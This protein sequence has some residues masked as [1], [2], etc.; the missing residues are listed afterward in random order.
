MRHVAL[1]LLGTGLVISAQ[2]AVAQV[3]VWNDRPAF[4]ASAGPVTLETF[5]DR[6]IF[7]LPSSINANTNACGTLTP[8]DCVTP[9]YLQPGITY[10]LP[11]GG[12]LLIDAGGGF[13]GA[14]LDAATP[15]YG[16]IPP[17]RLALWGSASFIGFDTNILAGTPLNV[18]VF[19]TG[20]SWSQEFAIAN[21]LDMQFL[22]FSRA[23]GDITAIELESRNPAFFFAAVD[24]V[25]F[26][27]GQTVVPEPSTV[28]LVGAGLLGLVASRRRAR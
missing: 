9:G 7:A 27:G 13:S 11:N 22:G 4:T 18:T 17:L 12:P 6:A 28:V 5:G 23:A 20:G 21:A 3:T 10:S 15:V 25:T 8:G 16:S 14:F 1:L 2:P 19:F 24:N 26:N